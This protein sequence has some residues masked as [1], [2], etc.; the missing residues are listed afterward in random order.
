[1]TTPVAN[2]ARIVAAL[3]ERL[4]TE[5]GL[6]D[7]DAALEDTLE[8]ASEL[9]ELLAMMAR[10][11]VRALD[12]H[13]AIE[14]RIRIMKERADRLEVRHDK[15]RLA[16]SWALQEAGW[17]RIPADALPDMSVTLSNGKRPLVIEREADIPTLFLRFKTVTEIKRKEL[18]EWLE[19]GNQLA[20]ARLSGTQPVLTIK[21]QNSHG[22]ASH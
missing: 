8:G 12:Y 16:I 1:M 4:K 18:R 10:D 15:I 6:D 5:Y 3:R 22:Q 13:E 20:A 19:D 11:A 7:S 17:K 2:A 21:E 9:P 14:Q